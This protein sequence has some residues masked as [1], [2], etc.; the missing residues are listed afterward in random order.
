MITGQKLTSTGCGDIG[1][2]GYTHDYLSSLIWVVWFG[3][4]FDSPPCEPIHLLILGR[5]LARVILLKFDLI[6]LSFGSEIY[7]RSIRA[8]S[9][10]TFAW[11]VIEAAAWT[12]TCCLARFEDSA[13]TSTSMIRPFAALRFVI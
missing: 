4:A 3:C 7:R 11:A 5:W 1:V 2:Y 10:E 8:T 13:A 12:K 6:G 9:F